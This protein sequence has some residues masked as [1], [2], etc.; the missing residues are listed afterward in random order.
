M[1]LHS[2][3]KN[4]IKNADELHPKIKLNR[5]AV[6]EIASRTAKEEIVEQQTKNINRVINKSTGLDKE[7]TRLGVK[8]QRKKQ[9]ELNR[10]FNSKEG[11]TYL[12][13][14]EKNIDNSIKSASKE[15]SEQISL[16]RRERRLQEAYDSGDLDK[17]E[18]L[19]RSLEGENKLSSPRKTKREIKQE[20]KKMFQQR[21]KEEKELEEIGEM[22]SGVFGGKGV[23]ER[24]NVIGGVRQIPVGP[25]SLE[26]VANPYKV[27]PKPKNNSANNKDKKGIANN[28][29]YRAA[30]AGVGGG[31]VLSMANNKG[32]QSNA[33]LYGQGGY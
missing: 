8:G 18:N 17:A 21:L 33:Q 15:T 28:F 5:S 24:D 2:T 23:N 11:R 3:I 16:A 29:V 20:R 9:D 26:G 19:F 30:A 10:L 27:E 6:K 22:Y 13:K 14:N 32:Q 7:A 4:L 1:G 31:L 25:T 12:N